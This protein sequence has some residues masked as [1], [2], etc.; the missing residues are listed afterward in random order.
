MSKIHVPIFS[1]S[2]QHHVSATTPLYTFDTIGWWQ[3]DHKV[4][5]FV[6]SPDLDVYQVKFDA[7]G[8]C[9]SQREVCLGMAG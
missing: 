4:E 8:N 9:I 3:D 1:T 2:G 5:G 6:C 7:N